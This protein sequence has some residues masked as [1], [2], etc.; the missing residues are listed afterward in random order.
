VTTHELAR[1]VL[2][3]PR[4]SARQELMRVPFRTGL[5]AQRQNRPAAPG[6]FISV[7]A[8]EHTRYRRLLTGQFTVHRMKQLEPRIEQITGERLDAMLRLGPG[9]DL[10]QEFA[11]P[12]PSLVICE[13]LGVPDTERGRFQRDTTT[14][15]DLK[16]G[17]EQAMAAYQSVY[18]LLGEVVRA[19]Q[20]EPTDDLLGGLAATNELTEEELTNIALLLLTAGHETTANMLALG[21]FALLSNPS[22]LTALREDPSLINNAVEE[23]MRYLTIVQF[24][25][26]RVAKED[27]E[28][29]N[30]HI[31]KGDLVVVA[32]NAANRDPRAFPD[33]DTLD[34]DRQMARHIAFGYGV[35][36]CLGQNVA[37]AELKTVLP[38]LFKRFPNLRLATP[39]E[40][41]PMDFTGTN[42]GVRKLM[43]TR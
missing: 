10:F 11:L 30:A 4:F 39:L 12:I 6:M 18:G 41:V 9:V 21:T 38:K 36:A 3:D 27:L 43:V 40:E 22:Q 28:I 24:G 23:L 1:E 19:K 16:A 34:I 33:P 25:L 35:H 2:T 14:L 26:G 37:R 20:A 29:G 15:V 7:D 32:M 17:P 31:K 5:A 13:L 42:Y 8:P